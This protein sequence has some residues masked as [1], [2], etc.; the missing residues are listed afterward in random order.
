[1]AQLIALLRMRTLL[2]AMVVIIVGNAL[3]FYAGGWRVS[4]FLLSLLTALGLQIVSNIAND[5]GDW[6]RG[7]DDNRSALAP[8][9]LLSEGHLQPS[10]VRS[11]LML[12]IVLTVVSGCALLWMAITSVEQGVVFALLGLLSIA[13]AI[14]YT[15]G[16]YAY[17]YHGLGETSVFLFFGWVGV[18]GSFSLQQ[19]GLPAMVWLPAS[20][21]GLLAAAVLNI[22]NMRDIASDREVGKNTLA[23]RLG[24]VRSRYFHAFLL[25]CGMLCYLL[26]AVFV[27]WQSALWLVLLPWVYGHGKRVFQATASEQ[28]A[29]ELKVIVLLTA[30][31]NLLFALGVV[32]IGHS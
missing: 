25:I 16:R 10:Q 3:A 17:G 20:G 1:M 24:F 9:R 26:F 5:Y 15:I 6:L 21:A 31:V 14:G 28:V 4:V 30:G 13:A 27:H 19:G 11:F 22:N 8:A 23:V 18:I 12:W 32:L 29:G 7:T 2:L